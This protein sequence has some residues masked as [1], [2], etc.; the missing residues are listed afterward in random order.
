M[1]GA[2]IQYMDYAGSGIVHMVGGTA[3]LVGALLT[4]PRLG[5]SNGPIPG[6][7]IGFQALGGFILMFG[8][9]AFN[10]GSELAINTSANSKNVG[11]AFISTLLCGSGGMI[12]AVIFEK[13]FG[14]TWDLSTAINGSLAGMVSACAGCDGLRPYAAVFVGLC[15]GLVYCLVA[16]LMN[17]L[18]IDD[19]LNAVAVHLGGGF[20]GVM[21]VPLLHEDLGIFYKEFDKHSLALL[22]WNLLGALAYFIWAGAT[23]FGMFY[24][25]KSVGMLR[26]SEE[27]ERAGLDV[28]KH[29][30]HGYYMSMDDNDSHSQTGKVHP[31]EA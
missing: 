20:L 23:S 4:G 1:D 18:K 16:S 12:S 25:L 26:V 6:H 8:F 3:A 5:R 29:G 28:S 10:G 14:K 27:V 7:N 24:L 11:Q 19:P 9:F 30:G 21:S 13:I 22:G 2:K 31:N 15:A 17:K